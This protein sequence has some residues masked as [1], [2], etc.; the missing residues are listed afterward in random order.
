MLRERCVGNEPCGQKSEHMVGLLH[1]MQ[2]VQAIGV[3]CRTL[4]ESRCG[5]RV[6][7]DFWIFDVYGIRLTPVFAQ[8]LTSLLPSQFPRFVSAGC[9][10][11]LGVA[12]HSLWHMKKGVVK[13]FLQ[14]FLT[15]S[16]DVQ[17]PR[18][19]YCALY[20]ARGHRSLQHYLT[21]FGHLC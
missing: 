5:S 6:G 12:W 7:S 11:S 18:Q 4:H 15:P 2:R 19:L 14:Y 1:S 21:K 13:S 10:T 17:P 16:M 8:A 9:L 20:L 3:I